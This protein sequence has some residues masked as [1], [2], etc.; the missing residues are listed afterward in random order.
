MTNKYVGIQIINLN[1]SGSKHQYGLY[2]KKLVLLI[3]LLI[4]STLFYYFE[5]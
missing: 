1:K 2:L 3:I 4:R 5:C